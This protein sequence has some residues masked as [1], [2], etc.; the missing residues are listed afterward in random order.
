MGKVIKSWLST[1]VDNPLTGA[2]P[3]PVGDA[4]SSTAFVQ[5]PSQ[6]SSTPAE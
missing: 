4:V 3:E 5:F 2:H 1:I 6:E